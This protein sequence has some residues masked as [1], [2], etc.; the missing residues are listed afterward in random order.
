M[1]LLVTMKSDELFILLFFL[2]TFFS[3]FAVESFLSNEIKV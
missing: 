3:D 1:Y 2:F